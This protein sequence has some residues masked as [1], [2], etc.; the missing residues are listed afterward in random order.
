MRRPTQTLKIRL[1]PIRTAKLNGIELRQFVGVL[2]NNN[3]HTEPPDSRIHTLI[4]VDVVL[5]VALDVRHVLHQRNHNR[6]HNDK[7]CRAV[8]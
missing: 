7:H 8:K 4:P 1:A 2:M 6:E 5:A 3:V